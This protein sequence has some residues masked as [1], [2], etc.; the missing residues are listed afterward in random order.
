[1][2]S[3]VFTNR[4]KKVIDKITNIGQYGYSK[5]KQ[6]QEVLLGLLSNIYEANKGNRKGLPGH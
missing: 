1:L 3:R 4:L 5:K 6:C 2:I